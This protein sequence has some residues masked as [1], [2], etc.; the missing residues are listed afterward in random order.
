MDMDMV[1]YL[2]LGAGISGL[3]ASYHLKQKGYESI[4]IEKE[5]QI[6]G[7]CRSFKINGFT[8]DHFIHLSFTQND[9]VKSIFNSQVDSI[10][11]IPNPHC[12]Y[13]GKW[14]KHPAQNNLFPLEVEEK[15]KV[16]ID[17]VNRKQIKEQT[18]ADWLFN[19]YGESF[20]KSFPM[21]YTR[22]YWGVEASELELEWIGKRMYKPSMEEVLRGMLTE[23]TPVTYY[24]K[25]MYYPIKGGYLSYIKPLAVGSHIQLNE[26]VLSIDLENK[27][28]LTTKHCYP[29][30]HLI[31]SL[32]LPALVELT[33][34]A[35]QY[36][37]DAANQLRYTSGYI[38][39]V[40]LKTKNIPP[41]LWMYVYDEDLLPARIYSP[42]LKSSNNAP[43]DCASIQ[44]EVY[45]DSRKLLK[46]SDETILKKTVNDLIRMKVINQED[47]LF[48]DIR[49]ESF[50]NVTFTHDVY[51][52]RGII[53]SFY[54]DKG[55]K[56]IGRFGRW[57]YFWSD[58]SLLSGKNL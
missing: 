53:R 38:I 1:D 36:L 46:E 29:Y 7:L 14:I 40:G 6:G 2:I 58:Q 51:Q 20:A 44:A 19:C 31:S 50:A 43:E 41:Y 47:I 42:S 17:F 8:F 3:S 55:I 23:D 24:A 27:T 26:R 22:K 57:E 30:R 9:Y 37:K 56:L 28:V 33:K 12:Y 21:R 13:Q 35:P 10:E 5:S 16:F 32:P 48:T 52:N 4:I 15:I 11:H 39:S 34:D 25:K 18:Y 45:V 49:F 54:E